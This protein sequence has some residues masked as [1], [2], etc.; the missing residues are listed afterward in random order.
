MIMGVMEPVAKKPDTCTLW[1]GMQGQILSCDSA[2]SDWF[3]YQ[4]QDLTGAAITSLAVKSG[5][6]LTA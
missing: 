5:N 3:A 6:K 1:V 2:F 4:P